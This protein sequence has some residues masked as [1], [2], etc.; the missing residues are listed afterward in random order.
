MRLRSALWLLISVVLPIH[1]AAGTIDFTQLAIGPSQ[2]WTLDGV[3]VTADPEYSGSVSSVIGEGLQLNS[4][5]GLVSL[6][7]L[8]DGRINSFTIL[9]YLTIDGLQSTDLGFEWGYRS[10]VPGWVSGGFLYQ[11]VAPPYGSTIVDVTNGSG[12][13]NE[14]PTE[15]RSIGLF[16]DFGQISHD[17]YREAHPNAVIDYG[18]WIQSLDFTPT[19]VP[20]PSTLVLWSLGLLVMTRLRSRN[21]R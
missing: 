4:T 13:L 21:R 1:A 10:F 12:D 18:F 8:V 17:I 2:S 5:D 11:Y 3:T 6:G 15:L 9:P 14:Q 7:I 16:S 19:Q 20:E